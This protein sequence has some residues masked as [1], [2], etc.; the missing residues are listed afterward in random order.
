MADVQKRFILGRQIFNQLNFY[1]EEVRILII[2]RKKSN[3][4]ELPS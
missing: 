1:I 2:N 3:S 4:S